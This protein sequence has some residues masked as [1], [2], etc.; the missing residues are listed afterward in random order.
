VD[1]NGRSPITSANTKKKNV[2][3]KV[4]L[5]WSGGK[6]SALALYEIRLADVYQVEALL[7]TVTEDYGRSSMHGVRRELLEKQ[8]ESVGYSLQVVLIPKHCTNEDYEARMRGTLE[9][10]SV[11]GVTGV[12]FGDVF[13]EGIRAYREGNL[14]RVGMKGIFPLWGKSSHGLAEMFIRKGFKAVVTCVDSEMLS[15]EY[16]GREYDRHF[17][18]D[19]PEPVDPCGE[20]G[21]FHTFV[22]DGP[23]FQNR[24]HFT[25]GEI[26]LRDNRFYFCDLYRG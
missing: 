26:V 18:E 15:G 4:L 19:L 6:D 25:R 1:E 12:G 5:A 23:I 21:E 9:R 14:S 11:R 24:I 10:W 2:R 22:Y 3:E 7:T 16:V 8:A 17:L 13:L 20:N